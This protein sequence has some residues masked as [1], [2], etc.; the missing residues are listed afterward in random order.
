MKEL[1]KKIKIHTWHN[2]TA[3]IKT[4][5]LSCIEANIISN[6]FYNTEKMVVVEEKKKKRKLSEE[7]EGNFV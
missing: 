4:M 1:I 5:P 2:I 7:S 3:F 6:I